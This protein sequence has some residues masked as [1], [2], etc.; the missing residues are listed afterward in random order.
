[1][2]YLSHAQV[3]TRREVGGQRLVTVLMYLTDVEDGGETVFPDV[4]SP[5]AEADV[6]GEMRST[7]AHHSYTGAWHHS[8]A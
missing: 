2:R 1:M 3:N 5:V 6:L 8:Y 4:I 7:H